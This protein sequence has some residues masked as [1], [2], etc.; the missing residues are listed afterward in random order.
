LAGVAT[1]LLL[2]KKRRVR[3]GTILDAVAAPL[4]GA[5]I[6]GK[7]GSFLGAAEV[8][9]KSQLPGAVMYAGYPDPRHPVQLYE[10][11]ALLVM[12]IGGI[13]L[14]RKARRR[15]WA[16][17]LVGSMFFL[18]YAASMFAFEFL[19][20]GGLYW[21]NLRANQWILLALF[22]ESAGALYVRG[23]G[24]IYVR[25]VGRAI[26]GWYGRISKQHTS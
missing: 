4:A 25:Q 26:G 21:W 19:K 1:L 18:V 3:M 5:A 20:E 2:A 11:G 10:I 9:I 12:L 7:V 8:G 13:V 16:F 17:G 6:V 23:G 22:C 15:R 14:E 24:R